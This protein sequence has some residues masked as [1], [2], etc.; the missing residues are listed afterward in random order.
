MRLRFKTPGVH[1]AYSNMMITAVRSLERLL[2]RQTQR[3]FQQKVQYP[4]V[5]EDMDQLFEEIQQLEERS[6]TSTAQIYRGGRLSAKNAASPHSTPVKWPSRGAQSCTHGGR[7]PSSRVRNMA[8]KNHSGQRIHR[9]ESATRDG[10]YSSA[11]SVTMQS[12]AHAEPPTDKASGITAPLRSLDLVISI[13]ALA[14]APLPTNSARNRALP[15]ARHTWRPEMPSHKTFSSAERAS[16]V[17]SV[18]VNKV[19]TRRSRRSPS[20]GSRTPGRRT[21]WRAAAGDHPWIHVQS[22]REEVVTRVAGGCCDER[23]GGGHGCGGW[24]AAILDGGTPRYGLLA[25]QQ[26]ATHERV[27]R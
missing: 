27:Q 26:L 17:Y 20:R 19:C 18:D 14:S 5:E 13:T 11:F 2:R 12:T 6:P 15:T 1:H 3:R 8:L 21:W 23:R 24:T 7:T 9:R 25:L 4:A 22:P 16:G 10:G